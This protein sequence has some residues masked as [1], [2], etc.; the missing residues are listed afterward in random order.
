MF[1]TSC[2]LYVDFNPQISVE[3][4]NFT[5][6][7]Y[8]HIK[9]NNNFSQH[10]TVTI[11]I[12]ALPLLL[13]YQFHNNNLFSKHLKKFHYIFSQKLITKKSHRN[14]QMLPKNRCPL[15]CTG[16]F[17][18]IWDLQ[19]LVHSV[20]DSDV[21]SD[22]WGKQTL[23]STPLMSQWWHWQWLQLWWQL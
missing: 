18:T 9:I 5:S 20:K 3:R 1:C 15:L 13:P 23:A 16:S 19:V 10:A 22:C 17:K 7:S 12:F 6:I 2:I 11:Y 4:K 8:F 21:V 14:F